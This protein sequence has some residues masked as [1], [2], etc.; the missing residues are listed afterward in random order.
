MVMPI[1]PYKLSCSS[2]Q[3]HKSVT[4]RSDLLTSQDIPKE[5]PVCGHEV[6]ISKLDGLGRIS[7]LLTSFLR[8]N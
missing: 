5:C 3:W 1:K 4:P 7:S 2:C 6:I 8:I